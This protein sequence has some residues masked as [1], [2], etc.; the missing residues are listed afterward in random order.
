M[1]LAREVYAATDNFPDRERFGLSAQL[2]RAAVSIPSN[3]AEAQGRRLPRDF[4][5]FLR[6]A[7]GSLHEVETQTLLS[8][9]FGYVA[10]ERA[11]HLLE[12]S[13]ELGRIINGLIAS[14]K[15]PD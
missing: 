5:S 4:R 15:D 11:K 7:R 6:K 3:I 13:A 8:A 10:G 1:I 14:L 9:D 2:R 12:L